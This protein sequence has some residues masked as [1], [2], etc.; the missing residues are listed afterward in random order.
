M[1]G[2][3]S[4]LEMP[5]RHL[6][7]CLHA[8]LGFFINGINFLSNHTILCPNFTN[9]YFLVKLQI[10]PSLSALLF[11]PDSHYKSG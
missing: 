7:Y 3:W 6:S 5:S 4:I 2:I 10:F 9:A 1:N 11:A 8:T